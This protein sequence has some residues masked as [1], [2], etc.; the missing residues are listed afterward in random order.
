MLIHGIDPSADYTGYG[1]IR[2][3]DRD[4]PPDL[5]HLEA[6]RMTD[7]LCDRIQERLALRIY[8]GD[9]SDLWII[10]RVPPAARADTGHGWQAAIGD[11]TGWIGGLVGGMLLA[12]D[13][14]RHPS[15]VRPGP[16]RASMLLLS[17]K[18]GHHLMRPKERLAL[19]K[20]PDTVGT[21][22]RADGGGFNLEWQDCDH[23]WFAND[24]ATL[25]RKPDTCPECGDRTRSRA[26][27]IRDAWKETAVEFVH[28]FWPEPLR[29][30]VEAARSR[31]RK[32]SKPM[33]QLAGVADACEAVGVACHAL[34][35]D[36]GA[37]WGV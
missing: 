33:H 4:K 2:P 31:A 9:R 21:V 7:E 36:Y 20:T 25:Q 18:W 23:V 11:S 27:R 22:K 24:L 35:P 30:L 17:T 13:Y 28:T 15:R 16:W 37:L 12:N 6:I 8:E 10:E 19:S 14:D 1:T 5:E 26:D 3:N 29:E 34:A 32:K